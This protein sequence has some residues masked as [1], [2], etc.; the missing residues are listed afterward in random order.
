[1]T[2]RHLF[3]RFGIACCFAFA[4]VAAAAQAQTDA[5]TPRQHHG[6][7]LGVD[8]AEGRLVV[9]TATG[10]QAFT[11]TDRTRFADSTRRI[12]AVDVAV[13]S[14]V[15]VQSVPDETDR[16]LVDFVQII[17]PKELAAG[18][19]VSD[20]S[21]H[22][23]FA[24]ADTVTIVGFDASR[25]ELSVQTLDGPRTFQVTDQTRI[26]SGKN[27][28]APSELQAGQRV[29]ISATKGQDAPI[30]RHISVVAV[31]AEPPAV[32]ETVQESK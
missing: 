4:L 27:T 8:P 20:L 30:A 15:V 23:A 26:R 11:I 5:A 28:L 14:T 17:D 12:E 16:W 7:V 9:E 29:A 25:S 6:Q 10:E 31:G 3:T 18:S 19:V 21:R 13:G 1:M 32:R 22:P 24:V 2:H